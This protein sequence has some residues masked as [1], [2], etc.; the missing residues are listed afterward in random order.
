MQ[1]KTNKKM[2][3]FVD[4]AGDAVFY[5][6]YGRCIVGDE[7]CS[8]ILL[9]GF[10][11]T[12]KPEELRGAI[13][14]LQKNIA[15]DKYLEMVPS[16]KKTLISFH[17]KNDCPEIR[18]KFYKL[19]V[20]LDF[21]AEFVVARKIES[22]FRKKHKGKENIFYDD[23]IAK[24]FQNKLHLAEESSIYFAVRGN[25]TRQ[26]PLEA[27]IKD[28]IG[29][30][31]NKWNI[32]IDSKIN[33]YPQSPSG[34]PCLQI[35]DYMNWAVQRA[36]IKREDRYLKFVE[37]KISYLADV[38]DFDNYPKNFYNR[39]NKFDLIKTSPL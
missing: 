16:L 22:I 20:N 4:E 34:E 8:K 39:K 13:A 3:F 11:K 30:F 18:E 7:G 10:I 31:E 15:K 24:L 35:A 36:L 14:E 21:K 33:I 32:K 2:Y 38:Y 27:A 9:L 25:K 23:L 6:K 17:A 28:A 29:I 5:N 19:I 37:E 12:E 1:T 26:E